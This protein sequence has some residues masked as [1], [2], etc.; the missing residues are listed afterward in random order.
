MLYSVTIR[1]AQRIA[2][3]EEQ[4]I[5]KKLENIARV[6]SNFLMHLQFRD[7]MTS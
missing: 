3:K 2:V 7:I 1:Q 4:V 5:K 6:S